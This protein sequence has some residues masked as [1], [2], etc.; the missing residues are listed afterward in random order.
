MTTIFDAPV[1][2]SRI[3]INGIVWALIAGWILA[4]I[5]GTVYNFIVAR[6]ALHGG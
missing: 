4:T 6:R 5:T 3:W 1:D 2:S